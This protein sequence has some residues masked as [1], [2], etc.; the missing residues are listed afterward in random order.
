MNIFFS[1]INIRIPLYFILFKFSILSIFFL[2]LN[3]LKVLWMDLTYINP[4]KEEDK[5]QKVVIVEDIK[6]YEEK[7]TV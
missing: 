2:F 3:F 6:K 5:V 4:K 1:Y 7:K